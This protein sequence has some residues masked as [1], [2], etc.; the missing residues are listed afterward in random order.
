M[1]AH[2]DRGSSS[3]AMIV[4][5]D[6]NIKRWR[7]VEE[8]VRAATRPLGTSNEL[9]SEVTVHLVSVHPVRPTSDAMPVW[10]ACGLVYSRITG[11]RRP[12]PRAEPLVLLGPPRAPERSPAPPAA[13]L[14]EPPPPVAPVDAPPA[15]ALATPP[16][17][18]AP[19]EHA[20]G[21]SSKAGKRG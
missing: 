12:D 2:H 8:A 16:L 14:L 18:L 20:A 15:L 13:E 11:Y 19:V 21:G 17:T 3:Q 5:T 1:R 6:I 10:P 7:G 4:L 9:C